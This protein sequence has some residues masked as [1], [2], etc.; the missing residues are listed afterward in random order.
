MVRETTYH[1]G[2][3]MASFAFSWDMVTHDKITVPHFLDVENILLLGDRP[4]EVTITDDL[5]K[6]FTGLGLAGGGIR[7]GKRAFELW[8]PPGGR[9]HGPK[10]KDPGVTRG[11]IVLLYKT[12]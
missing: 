9:L 10:F 3:R 7:I 12:I 5:Q 2:A 4:I 11:Y 1:A 6:E 8:R